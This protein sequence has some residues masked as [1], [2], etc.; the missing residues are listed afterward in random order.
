MTEA[1]TDACCGYLP[2]SVVVWYLGCC[3]LQMMY[4]SGVPAG[5]VLPRLAVASFVLSFC[6]G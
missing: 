1:S 3:G 4:P 6:C 2:V 5:A